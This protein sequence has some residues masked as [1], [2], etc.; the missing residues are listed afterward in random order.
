MLVTSLLL[1]AALGATPAQ[2]Q[3]EAY[4]GI[5][6]I[7]VASCS[8]STP[9]LGIPASFAPTAPNTGSIAISFANQGSKPVSSV[10]F[11]VVGGGTTTQIVDTGLFSNGARIRH[12]FS[13]PALA[14]VNGDVT[15]SVQAVA[16]TDGS[17]WQAQ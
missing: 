10:T 16:F 12:S 11:D 4:T 15:C 7:Q 6:P 9:A 1:S 2:P 3:L 8:I 5:N 17:V 14:N 13:A